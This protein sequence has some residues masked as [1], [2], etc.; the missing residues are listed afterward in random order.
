[1]LLACK[2]SSKINA[3]TVAFIKPVVNYVLSN[4]Q[5]FG[6]Y[7]FQELLYQFLFQRVF[8]FIPFSS[9]ISSVTTTLRW[10]CWVVFLRRIHYCDMLLEGV[11]RVVLK[12]SSNAFCVIRVQS[13]NWKCTSGTMTMTLTTDEQQT[14]KQSRSLYSIVDSSKL[15]YSVC[16]RLRVTCVTLMINDFVYEY[17][18]DFFGAG[19]FRCGAP[20]FSPCQCL[21]SSS[22]NDLSHWFTEHIR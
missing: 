19:E 7:N 10:R 11:I 2:S 4:I 20:D 1:M 22:T 8:I 12:S 15:E 5:K 18:C 9:T 17:S 21:H 13:V 3:F 6:T 16:G 14:A